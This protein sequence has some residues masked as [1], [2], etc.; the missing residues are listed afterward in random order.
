MEN[1]KWKSEEK[2]WKSPKKN[3]QIFNQNKY[4]ISLFA[5]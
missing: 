1:L 3:L 2:K 5:K 4:F